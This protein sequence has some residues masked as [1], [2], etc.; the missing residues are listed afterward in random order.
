MAENT[1]ITTN[2]VKSS[3]KQ[4]STGTSRHALVRQTQLFE[5]TSTGSFQGAC[6]P[7]VTS[8]WS[9]SKTDK[10]NC[11]SHETLFREATCEFK[12]RSAVNYALSSGEGNIPSSLLL[13]PRLQAVWFLLTSAE[14][15]NF[16]FSGLRIFCTN[17]QFSRS[18]TILLFNFVHAPWCSERVLDD[19]R[20]RRLEKAPPNGIHHDLSSSTIGTQLHVFVWSN[21]GSSPRYLVC[22]SLGFS[23]P[24]ILESRIF[25]N[26]HAP[27]SLQQSN[28][29]LFPIRA[30]GPSRF[31]Q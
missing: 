25:P 19:R 31:L 28:V 9:C 11:C 1:V 13:T 12:R 5:A 30:G 29:G 14:C 7:S 2:R 26:E 17:F 6:I 4:L 8:R 22:A 15:C 20:N 21:N 27:T 16:L 10:S 23:S 24:H 18:V 3:K